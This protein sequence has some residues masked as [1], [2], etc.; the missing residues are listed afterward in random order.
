MDDEAMMR[1]EGGLAAAV[2]A[3]S[4]SKPNSQQRRQQLLNFKF[5]RASLFP[6]VRSA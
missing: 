5:R 3:A 4:A 1:L 2:R 6:R